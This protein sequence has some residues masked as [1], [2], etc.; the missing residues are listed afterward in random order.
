MNSEFNHNLPK[1]IPP[2]AGNTELQSCKQIVSLIAHEMRNPLAIISSNLQLL[3]SGRYQLE[4][5]IIEDSFFLCEEAIRSM[6][7]FIGEICFVNNAFKSRLKAS[8]GTVELNTLLA[9]A[10]A[11]CAPSEF[12]RNRI[13][14]EKQ[15]GLETVYSDSDMLRR[16]VIQLVR[17]ALD[18]SSGTVLV[19]L[20]IADNEF[21]IQVIDQ[22]IGIPDNEKHLIFE[23]FIRCSNVKMASGSGIGLAIVKACVELLRGRIDFESVLNQGTRFTV[24]I[25]IHEFEKGIDNR[26]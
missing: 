21:I 5:T 17:N 13:K 22:G 25:S 26:R 15:N 12:N 23:P 19:K 1:D 14:I 24:K 4:D 2:L 8:F 7:E 18:F 3:K 9:N 6:S 20:E 16:I 10:L 11:V